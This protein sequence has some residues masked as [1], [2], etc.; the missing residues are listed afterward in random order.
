MN[1]FERIT[2]SILGGAIGD[3]LAGP[4]EWATPPVTIDHQL[5]WRLS[6]DTQLTLATCEAISNSHRVDPAIISSTFVRWYR[7]SLL[8]GLGASTSKALSELTIGGHWALVGRKGEMA[9]GNGAAMRI[10][11]LAFCLN[12]H[13]PAERQVIRD[14]CRITHHNEES[15]AGA[16]AILLAVRGAFLGTWAGEANLLRLVIPYLPDTSVRDRLMEFDRLGTGIS[17]EDAA[18]RFG[19]SGYVV[20]SVPMALLGAQQISELGFTEL[21]ES[22]VKTGGDTDTIAS[23]AGQVCGAMLGQKGLP[24]HLIRRLPSKE[25]IISIAE[26]FASTVMELSRERGGVTAEDSAN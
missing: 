1:S 8:T 20:E 22:I 26:T 16:L 25:K 12:P 19:T 21:M 15:Y 18:I 5:E 23:M 10:A 3:A 17:L 7:D 2:G 14:V 4:Y 13:E 11:P 9:A 24:A 6:D